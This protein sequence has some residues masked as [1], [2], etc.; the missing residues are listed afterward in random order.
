MAKRKARKSRRSAASAASYLKGV[1]VDRNID[2]ALVH[3]LQFA[4]AAKKP[5]WNPKPS[6]GACTPK[7]I[8]TATLL[9]MITVGGDRITCGK[10]QIFRPECKVVAI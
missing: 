7:K 5:P 10:T 6:A 4:I 8:C 9:C 3:S 1:I 2:D